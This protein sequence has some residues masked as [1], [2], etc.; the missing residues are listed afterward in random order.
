MDFSWKGFC[1]ENI[2]GIRAELIK[3]EVKDLSGITLGSGGLM[4]NLPKS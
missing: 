1:D 4:C 3:L 2:M